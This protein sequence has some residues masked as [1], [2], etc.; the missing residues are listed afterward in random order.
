MRWQT[1][2][3]VSSKNSLNTESI[4]L[5]RTHPEVA[6]K[7]FNSRRL[8][9]FSLGNLVLL[10]KVPE[11][12]QIPIGLE[13]HE[14]HSA[15]LNAHGGHSKILGGHGGHYFSI[16]VKIKKEGSTVYLWKNPET[17][18]SVTSGVPPVFP[19]ACFSFG[20]VFSVAKIDCF[21]KTA[22]PRCLTRISNTVRP[23]CRQTH[24][25]A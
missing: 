1:H 22:L 13:T 4:L 25:K 12:T 14:P 2:K 16:R 15:S 10:K 5:F 20:R 23:V 6:K 9:H 19:P 24:V 11:S 8:H 7:R 3:K 21:T 18:T 17:V